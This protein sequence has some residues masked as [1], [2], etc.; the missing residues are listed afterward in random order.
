MDSNG[1]ASGGGMGAGPGPPRDVGVGSGKE[2]TGVPELLVEASWF[3][4]GLFLGISITSF[5]SEPPELEATA[6]CGL[7]S[8]FPGQ[9][10]LTHLFACFLNH[11]C[12]V[13]RDVGHDIVQQSLVACQSP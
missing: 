10:D 12:D 7:V 4:P 3:K 8:A 1:R 9:I 5:V 2:T 13:R 11:G 6:S